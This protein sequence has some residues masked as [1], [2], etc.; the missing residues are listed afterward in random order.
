MN[1]EGATQLLRNAIRMRHLSWSTEETYAH[2]LVQFCGF[3]RTV[4]TGLPSEQKI[5]RWLTSL[6]LKD[7]AASTQNQA[8]N[9]VLF[10]YR[11]C[12]RQE[13]K[14]INSLR[15][16]RGER[17]RRAPSVEEVRR[18]R[19]AVR[20]ASGYPVKFVVDLIYG[21]GFRVTEPLNLRVRDI[22]LDD[23]KFYIRG[24]K[25]NK[26]RVV[27]IPCSLVGQ[28][29]AQLVH[30]RVTWQ[31]DVAAGLPIQLPNRVAQK[32]PAAQFSWQWAWLFPLDHPCPDPRSGR[33]VRWRMLESVVQRAVKRACAR[34]GLAI[35]PHELRHGYGTHCLNRGENPRAIQQA[36]GHSSLETTMGYLHAEALGVQSPLDCEPVS[37]LRRRHIPALDPND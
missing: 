20:D 16:K 9:A 24:A 36:M 32:Y 7:V 4:P 18:L 2:W 15:A 10:F 12:L 3:V 6:A 14:G 33:M 28:I 30:A 26:D 37:A 27:G 8:F 17:V 1:T 5:E 22:D 23:S 34:T 13:L 25:G 35:V 29:R 21:C 31:R 11:H 19:E